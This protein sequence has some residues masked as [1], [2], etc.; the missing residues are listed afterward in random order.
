[1]SIPTEQQAHS[2]T[3]DAAG[4]SVKLP[5]LILGVYVMNKGLIVYES[6]PQELWEN[7]EIKSRY[8][9]F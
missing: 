5:T 9:G 4:N 6:L 8:L 3:K 2:L 1:M 7:Q